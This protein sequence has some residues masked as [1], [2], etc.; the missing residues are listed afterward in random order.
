MAAPRAAVPS[1]LLL[2][3]LPSWAVL[4]VLLLL[5]PSVASSTLLPVVPAVPVL[6]LLAVLLAVLPAV[7]LRPQRVPRRLVSLPLLAQARRVE[8]VSWREPGGPDD[9]GLHASLGAVHRW[10][11]R[12]G[13]ASHVYVETPPDRLADAILGRAGRVDADL[14]V[15]GAYGHARW[16]ERVLGGATRAMLA[17]MTM[18]VLMSH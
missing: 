16:A 1:T 10:L 13:V 3:S 7:Q 14:I 9:K 17:A 18:P 4:A 6:L 8:L 5:V 2:P 15:M 12:H 11:H